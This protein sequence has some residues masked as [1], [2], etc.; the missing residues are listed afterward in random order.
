M[1]AAENGAP[2][3]AADEP[4]SVSISSLPQN[5]E[6]GATSNPSQDSTPLVSTNSTTTPG[7]DLVQTGSDNADSSVNVQNESAINEESKVDDGAEEEGNEKSTKAGGALT[8]EEGEIGP[9]PLSQTDQDTDMMLLDDDSNAT[10]EEDGDWLTD[11]NLESKRVKVYELIGSKWEDQGTAFCTGVIQDETGEAFLVARHETDASQVVLTTGIKP[12]DVYQRQQETLIVWTEPNGVDYALSFQDADGCSEVWNFI[13]EVQKHMHSVDQS[14]SPALNPSD[15]FQTGR[16]AISSFLRD[17]HLPSP[18]LGVLDQIE[19]TIRSLGRTQALKER[20]CEYLIGED[21]LRQIISVFT[22]AE[23]LED[24]DNLHMICGL[25]QTILMLNDHNI[26][27]HILEDELFLDVLGMLEY[28]P[29]FPHHKG[30]YREF[31]QQSVHYHQPI[32]IADPLIKR[33]IHQTFRLQFLKDVVLA[34]TLE[35]ST[36]NVLNSCIIFNQ[37]DIIAHVQGEPSFLKQVVLSFVEEKVMF[38]IWNAEIPGISQRQNGQQKDDQMDVDSRDS[39][40]SRTTNGTVPP[41]LTPEEVSKR[42]EVVLLVQQLCAMGKNIQLPARLQLFRTLVERGIL[43]VVQWALGLPEQDPPPT[44][45]QENT[46]ADSAD[47]KPTQDTPPSPPSHA[48]LNLISAAGEILACTLDHDLLGVR[49]FLLRQVAVI[50]KGPVKMPFK[51]ESVLVLLCRIMA[52][53]KDL[54]VQS[55]AGDCLKTWLEIP[56]ESTGN[57]TGE[58]AGRLQTGGKKD[59]PVNE[60][61]LEYFYKTAVHVL[62][63]PLTD[64]SDWKKLP[65]EVIVL[66]R[67]TTNRYLLLCDILHSMVT[68]HHFRGYLFIISGNIMPKIAGLLRTKDKHL[69]HAAFRFF[70]LILKLNN[71]TLR[72]QMIK[73]EVFKP[74]LDLTLQESKRDNLLSC[75]CQEFFEAI[76]KDNV[77]DLITHCMTQYRPL[78]DQLAESPLGAERFTLFIKRHEINMEPPPAPSEQ[79]SSDTPVKKSDSEWVRGKAEEDYFIGGDDDDDESDGSV[80]SISGQHSRLLSSPGGVGV[81]GLKRKR[82]MP[83]LTGSPSLRGSGFRSRPVRSLRSPLES[84]S[85]YSDDDE[86]EDKGLSEKGKVDLILGPKSNGA[87]GP[88]SPAT[89]AS[90]LRSPP[91]RPPTEDDD[92]DNLL[93]NLYNKSRNASPAPGRINIAALS[94]PSTSKLTGEKRRRDEDGD[95]AMERLA[96]KP[97]L[98][99]DKQQPQSPQQQQQQPAEGADPPASPAPRKKIQL[100]LGAV[101][102]AVVEGAAKDGDTG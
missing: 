34:R 40:F 78:I 89:E 30:N 55:L 77:K 66:S 50:Q 26:Y 35:D 22:I 41:V 33:K 13:T 76:K 6:E 20:L 88:S 28:D 93:E 58:A 48:N 4:D 61:F 36:F 71:V 91:R 29:E 86:D 38:A 1:S 59:D 18:S 60:N 9:Q 90:S 56:L 84:L 96:K 44:A 17:N 64:L 87:A 81:G 15:S 67:E 31:L 49:Q 51:S 63:K 68:Q 79:S 27:D 95:D 24:L 53:S 62:M 73:S 3:T 2:K 101:G 102:K 8:A 32:E 16:I 45:P 74:I 100:K 72:S 52:Q 37:I 25:M 14:S 92:Q 54:A 47:S 85:D 75:S 7:D 83:P 12:N 97:D 19:L 21:Y 39:K 99:L 10:N 42:K 70:R 57:S 43:F 65:D 98:G 46:S 94:I 11:A 23:D 82:G 5:S 69:K 80:L